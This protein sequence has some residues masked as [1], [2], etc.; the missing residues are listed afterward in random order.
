MKL[1]AA[2]CDDEQAALDDEKR[3]IAEVLEEKHIE[4]TIDTFD[5]AQK[6][7][8]SGI[9]HDIVFLDVEMEGMDGLHTARKLKENNRNCI[10]CFVTNHE[11]YLDDAFDR[12]A[13]RFWTKPLDRHKL[14]YG[15]D[16]A[17]KKINADR[18]YIT[19]MMGESQKKLLVSDILYVYIEN[20]HMHLVMK[21]GEILIN[22]TYKEIYTQL[23]KFRCFGEP[24]RGYCVN[25]EYV[26]SYT[27]DRIF[28]GYQ[29]K[30]YQLDISRRKYKDFH[31]AMMDWIGGK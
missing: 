14:I 25:F 19:V 26:T 30:E 3:I 15:I 27:H 18:Q 17:I 10:I 20:K 1:T 12:D 29:N 6:L 21:K 28:I 7:I 11:A 9:S 16:S 4:Y 23:E 13:F 2:I 22:N 8:E 24:C 5:N 31:N